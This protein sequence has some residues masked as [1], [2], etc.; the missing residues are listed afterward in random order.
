M[1]LDE[2]RRE[3]Q[4]LAIQLAQFESRGIAAGILF[5]EDEKGRLRRKRGGPEGLMTLAEY[6]ALLRRTAT[7]DPTGNSPSPEDIVFITERMTHIF[8]STQSHYM[9]FAASPEAFERASPEELIQGRVRGAGILIRNPGDLDDWVALLRRFG[10]D[11]QL[12]LR[13]VIGFEVED[14]VKITTAYSRHTVE[15]AAQAANRAHERY[16]DARRSFR[17]ERRGRPYDRTMQKGRDIKRDLALK[18]RA[19]TFA[20][21]REALCLDAE[22]L[23]NLAGVATDTAAAFIEAFSTILPDADL[24]HLLLP[25]PLNPLIRTPIIQDDIGSYCPNP[26][27]LFWALL[28]R[29]ADLLR[30]HRETSRD[31][32]LAFHRYERNIADFV[33]RL[34]AELLRSVGAQDVA[35]Q[36]SYTDVGDGSTTPVLTEADA[37]GLIDRTLILAECKTGF[38]SDAALRG[39]PKSL[40]SELTRSVLD[41]QQQSDRAVRAAA[42][43]TFHGRNNEVLDFR[44]QFDDAVR[45]LIILDNTPVI[46]S[47]MVS[48]GGVDLLGP[49]PGVPITLL[50][51][52]YATKLLNTPWSWKHYFVGRAIA[53]R[54]RYMTAAHDEDDFLALYVLSGRAAS[55]PTGPLIHIGSPATF[56]ESSSDVYSLL[57]F[58]SVAKSLILALAQSACPYWTNAVGKLIELRGDYTRRL[59]EIVSK[60]GRNSRGLLAAEADDSEIAV[61]PYRGVSKR[62]VVGI[63]KLKLAA[64]PSRKPRLVVYWDVERASAAVEFFQ[65]G[66]EPRGS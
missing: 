17:K 16:D 57:R 9:Q 48:Y 32:T 66:A 31:G 58:D 55:P 26:T 45:L 42:V 1:G 13:E 60:L 61:A 62:D 64:R 44:G 38:F 59:T 47:S 63:T 65:S 51:L 29:I 37:V 43:T 11:S 34:I 52:L 18:A 12:R 30:L 39:A 41:A 50:D 28:P 27:L 14:A 53:I 3:A 22:R 15:V 21:L 33:E 19:D 4:T 36:V 49:T 23:S 35:S 20:E 7:T 10:D 6:G 46:A 40:A 8:S 24:P 54:D 56:L 5:S 2:A 25:S